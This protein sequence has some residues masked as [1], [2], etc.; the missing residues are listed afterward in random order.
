MGDTK[1]TRQRTVQKASAKFSKGV[2]SRMEEGSTAGLI[3]S[4][5]KK[6]ASAIDGQISGLQ[7]QI[8]EKTSAL[9]AAEARLLEAI[10]P[11]ED[12]TNPKGYCQAI[13]NAQLAVDQA[14]ADLVATEDSLEYF[15]AL[16]KERF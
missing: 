7:Y 1:A 5:A 10:Y 2:Q 15:Q 9:E 6:A 8:T 16:K 12:I 4:I 14:E 13:A 3:E 11:K